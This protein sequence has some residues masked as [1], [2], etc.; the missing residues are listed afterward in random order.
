MKYDHFILFTIYVMSIA[1]NVFFVAWGMP[2]L[3]D[4]VD[5]WRGA[6]GRECSKFNKYRNEA[7]KQGFKLPKEFWTEERPDEPDEA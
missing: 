4:K 5:F 3:R 1:L 2:S 6:W 7:E